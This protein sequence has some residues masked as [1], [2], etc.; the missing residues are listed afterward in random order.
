MPWCIVGGIFI[1]SFLWKAKSQ[2]LT[3]T[4]TYITFFLSHHL[5]A[6]HILKLVCHFMTLHITS[7]RYPLEHNTKCFQNAIREIYLN[8]LEQKRYYYRPSVAAPLPIASCHHHS[9]HPNSEKEHLQA[10][11]KEELMFIYGI[12]I[13]WKKLKKELK[14]VGMRRNRGVCR[15]RTEGVEKKEFISIFSFL[16]P[17]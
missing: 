11:N 2:K 1:H 6:E 3:Y 14:V 15:S 8:R 13:I 7:H 10:S 17:V 12:I 16:A 5:T 4:H 9:H